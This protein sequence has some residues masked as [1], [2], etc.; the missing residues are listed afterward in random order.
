MFYVRLASARLSLLLRGA[1]STAGYLPDPCRNSCSGAWIRLVGE[2]VQQGV[3]HVNPDL[4]HFLGNKT[5]ESTLALSYFSFYFRIIYLSALPEPK[6]KKRK[7][8][9]AN[10]SSDEA[11]PFITVKTLLPD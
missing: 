3:R 7:I 8:S 10:S 1:T 2:K 4:A 5:T 6:P 9:K 11:T